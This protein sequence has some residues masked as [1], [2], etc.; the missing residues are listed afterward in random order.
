MKSISL[1]AALTLIVFTG[2]E[3]GP[4]LPATVP[5]EGKVTLDGEAV[6]DAT[7]IFIADVG[8]YNAT[9]NTDKNGFFKMKAFEEKSG[10][11]P[12]SYKVEVSKTIVES[13][14]NK[15]G[16]GGANV[17]YGLPKKYSSMITSGLTINLSDKGD[18]DIKF[19]LKS[20]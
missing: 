4:K 17:K 9:S 19:E 16:E 8:S 2:C 10:A 13:T 18:K 14:G 20:K 6:T 12:G 3:S 11:V 15:G 5:A 7:V 1:F